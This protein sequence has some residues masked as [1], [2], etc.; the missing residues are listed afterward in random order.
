MTWT[1]N[2]HQRKFRKTHI[3]WRHINQNAPHLNGERNL[4]LETLLMLLI[5]LEGGIMPLLLELKRNK[6]EEEKLRSLSKFIMKMATKLMRLE[7]ILVSQITRKNLMHFLLKLLPTAQ[8]LN[9]FVT[10]HLKRKWI[11]LM[12]QMTWNALK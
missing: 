4:I 5:L 6:M 8:L 2:T 11:L 7:N 9:N 1:M 12:T 3:Y 10:N